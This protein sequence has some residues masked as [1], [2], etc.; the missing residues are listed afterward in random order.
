VRGGVG[1]SYTLDSTRG[2]YRQQPIVIHQENDVGTRPALVPAQAEAM[3]KVARVDSVN[4]DKE[5]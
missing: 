3:S 2:Q 5:P 1:D 4:K